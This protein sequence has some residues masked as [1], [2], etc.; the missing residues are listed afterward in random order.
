MYNHCFI[1]C[2]KAPI[3][4]NIPIGGLKINQATT[5][6][7][8][9]ITETR[10]QHTQGYTVTLALFDLDN[11]LIKG[12]SD[13]AWGEFLV[14][15]KLVD[16][17]RIREANNKF[18]ADYQQGS[19]D[20][21]EYL[22]FA[23]SFLAGKT[24]EELAPLHAQFMTQY[25]EPIILPLGVE[26][27]KRHTD[28]GHTIVMI[29]ATNRF[30]T[31]PIAQRLGIKHLIACEPEIIDDTYTGNATGTP[32]FQHGKVVRLQQWLEH[33]NQTLAGS[34]FYSDSHNDLPLLE[35]V[36]HPVAVNPDDRLREIAQQNSW[37][38][39]DLR[40]NA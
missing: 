2:K 3:S 4:L 10:P 27:I 21:D 16:T 19:L 26:L 35:K 14:A 1:S 5:K 22:R 34:Y 38:I 32:S 6:K 28:Q 12:D 8:T 20:I 17:D 13:H 15:N 23:L 7:Q 36:D 39:M 37:T 33:S 24:T 29:T 40:G 11:T 31:G 30:V 9:N 25:I 18:L